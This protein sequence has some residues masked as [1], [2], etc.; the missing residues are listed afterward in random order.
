MPSWVGT[1]RLR[2]KGTLGSY[3]AL[4]DAKGVNGLYQT[5]YS[6]PIE[7]TVLDPCRNSTLRSI[8]PLVTELAVPE[9][10]GLIK[11]LIN[12]P[13]DSISETY[14][15]GYDKCGP[16]SYRFKGLDGQ[17]FVFGLF[18]TTLLAQESAADILEA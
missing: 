16:R 8:D 15:N 18:S 11:Q 3:S 13:T 5:V 14:G 12:G 2:V 4:P 10:K 17:P 6:A 7:L 9:G 1:H